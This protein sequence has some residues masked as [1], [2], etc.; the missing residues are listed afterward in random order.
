MGVEVTSTSIRESELLLGWTP[1][2][3]GAFDK[4]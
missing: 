3:R 4:R 1:T 2:S